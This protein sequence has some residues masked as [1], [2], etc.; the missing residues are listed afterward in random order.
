M[1]VMAV[2][3]AE[4][5]QLI[6]TGLAVVRSLKLLKSMSHSLPVPSH[7]HSD[8]TSSGSRAGGVDGSGGTDVGVDAEGNRSKGDAAAADTDALDTLI[9]WAVYA[10]FQ[11]YILTLE[12]LVRWIPGYYSFKG[13][14]A[15][16]ISLPLLRISNLI[17]K[18]V[19]VPGVAYLYEKLG[20]KN[21]ASFSEFFASLPFL[22]LLV[23]FPPLGHNIVT[24][25]D[26]ND[27]DVD[28]A[29]G[30][31]HS[32]LPANDSDGSLADMDAD[33]LD[34]V[35]SRH[36]IPG[37]FSHHTPIA[38]SPRASA[39]FSVS[40]SGTPKDPCVVSPIT[41]FERT[42]AGKASEGLEE[43]RMPIPTVSF[44]AEVHTS[45]DSVEDSKMVSSGG[46]GAGSHFTFSSPVSR[47]EPG[48]ADAD[49]TRPLLPST[50]AP[51]SSSLRYTRQTSGSSTGSIG[52][53]RIHETNRR[54]S[55][56]HDKVKTSRSLMDST[57]SMLGRISPRSSVGRPVATT[58]HS[59]S[60]GSAAHGADN[61][62]LQHSS[63]I[64]TTRGS[65]RSRRIVDAVLMSQQMYPEDDVD[66]SLDVGSHG[67]SAAVG[68]DNEGLTPNI[69]RQSLRSRDT[70]IR[71]AQA[72]AGLGGGSK[73]FGRPTS[74]SAARSS[75]GSSSSRNSMAG[76]RSS[77]RSSN[78]ASKDDS[79]GPIPSAS[80]VPTIRGRTGAVSYNSGTPPTE[81]SKAGSDTSSENTTAENRRNSRSSRFNLTR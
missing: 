57:L 65:S 28:S 39:V 59:R 66:D 64:N 22:L 16:L 4:S 27:A 40:S 32:F 8:A 13:I 42:S 77:T 54:L 50:S 10:A 73:L 17:F 15:L 38:H 78:L 23:V 68:A 14:F 3:F 5:C 51:S 49:E 69:T 47:Q 43:D 45:A 67:S 79:T 35:M 30:S 18:E 81:E 34:D 71:Q 76:T 21:Y 24:P 12:R 37:Q 19:M 61:D 6:G 56:F 2:A 48:N 72:T 75:I 11:V 25:K 44:T 62:R 55:N 60:T 20:V 9:C 74:S 46:A 7:D 80:A 58:F 36:I 1:S 53:E 41:P 63:Y 52:D 70:S 31:A 33:D 26:V 29:D